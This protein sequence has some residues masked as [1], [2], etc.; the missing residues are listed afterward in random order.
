LYCK[1]FI[2]KIKSLF[3]IVSFFLV[4]Q[5]QA[6]LCEGSLGDAVVN[7]DFGSG[8]GRGAALG[9]DITAYTYSSGTNLDEGV[10]TIANSTS[11]LKLDAWLVTT[12]HTGDTNGY[13]MVINS[14]TLESEGVFYTKSVTG[15]CA[16]TTYQFSAWIMNI[17][18][19]SVGTDEYSPDVTFRVTD[20][21]G[22]VLNS[23]DTGSI[24]QSTTANWQEYGFYFTL[25]SYTDVVITIL[26]SA[27][28]A[29]P[30]N[31]I[32]LDDITFKACGPDV[33]ASIADYDSTEF[34]I[35]ENGSVTYTLTGAVGTSVYADPAYQWQISTDEGTT[36][37]DI[38]GATSTTYDILLTT[39]GTYLYRMTTAESTNMSS[40]S[41]RVSSNTITITVES[42]AAPTGSGSQSFCT[43]QN[44]TLAD[45]EITGT[46]ISWYEDETTDVALAETT[47]LV[48]GTTYYAS[49][50]VD[51]CVS[52]SRLAVLVTIISPTL[53]VNDVSDTICD[54][55]NDGVETV[56]LTSYETE[57][58][59]CTDCVFTYYLS[60]SA[61]QNQTEADEVSTP[62]A[63]DIVLGTTELYVRI[64][65]SD[66]CYQT[67][68]LTLV[69]LNEPDILIDDTVA[70]CE[71]YD[72]T[73][74]PGTGFDSYLWS[75]GETSESITVA[76]EGEYWVTVSQDNG[77]TVC[78]VTKSFTVV[79]SNAAVISTI[80]IQDFTS[81][82]NVIVV[83]LTDASIGDYEYSLE[84]TNYQDSNTFTGLDSGE[85]TV[86]VRDK[87]D[88][89]TVSQDVVILSYPRFFTP[90]GDG[91]NDT[92]A[93]DF[94]DS[95]PTIVTDIFDR[96]GKFIKELDATSSWDGTLN[97]YELP[98]TDYWFI[99]K[100]ASGK[101]YKSHFALKR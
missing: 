73:I 3:S 45:I 8:T 28:S 23:Y 19:P 64:D 65:S 21:A 94:S 22:N 1:F 32:A 74:S 83:E 13:M 56:D 26:N 42:T 81:D 37:T 18:D 72:V 44:A 71:N 15:L 67:A 17:M 35:C 14:A 97:G 20:S 38:D 87:N 98:S 78:S 6:Q 50:T 79:M 10:Y 55:S 7:I 99:V 11:G 89:G 91:Y 76:T 54:Y 33:T 93:I 48:D 62:T 58:V 101:V 16:G 27:P 68:Q 82:D 57:I 92:W 86:Y 77:N 51:T 49:Q 31:D 60:L 41:C 70:Y 46:G 24:S 47:S 52:D 96:Y 5:L 36:W 9:S 40:S 85:Y 59:N 80:E 34:T 2:L 75:T 61:A 100:R 84:G 90:N 43:T 30:G 88:C 39:L 69:L 63:Y 4:F 53:V 12:D 29:N 66:K 95:E 25:G